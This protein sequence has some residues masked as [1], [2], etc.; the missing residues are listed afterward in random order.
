ML[1]TL[2]CSDDTRQDDR[3]C[4]ACVPSLSLPSQDLDEAVLEWVVEQLAGATGMSANL[5]DSFDFSNTF[6]RVWRLSR[7]SASSQ[8][9]I[10]SAHQ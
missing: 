6:V 1:L 5:S 10:S 9:I 8:S 4:E 7:F 2:E 3:T